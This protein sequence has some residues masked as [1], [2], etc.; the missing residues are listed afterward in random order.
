MRYNVYGS[1]EQKHWIELLAMLGQR[2][3][4]DDIGVQAR[5]RLSI[6]HGG[7]SPSVQRV[8]WYN[9]ARVIANRRG[10]VPCVVPI[11]YP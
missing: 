7:P 11:D 10:S 4:Q 9:I 3:F 2:R 1:E 8:N 5:K 6:D